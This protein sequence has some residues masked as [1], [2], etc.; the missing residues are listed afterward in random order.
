[1]A[2]LLAHAPDAGLLQQLAR[3]GGDASPLGLAHVALAEAASLATVEKVSREYFN[4]FIG[5][6]RGELLP[7][8][9]YYLAGFLH[10]R[11]LARL[12]GDL[13][14]LGIERAAGNPEPED[15]AATLCEV[16]AG[17]IR[18]DFDA[19]PGAEAAFFGKHIEPWFERLFEDLVRAEHAEFYRA[20]GVLGRVFIGIERDAFAL[21]G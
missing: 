13:A 9:S 21:P 3:L 8:G 15:H 18:G 7:Y 4:L 17:L 19:E 1:L 14:T 10:E 5:I 2:T 6:G 12:R 16:M 20:V 11:P